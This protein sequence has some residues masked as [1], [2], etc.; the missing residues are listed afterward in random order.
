M[1]KIFDYLC[2]AVLSAIAAISPWFYGSVGLE[3]RYLINILCIL[4]LLIWFIKASLYKEEIIY[5][6]AYLSLF[7]FFALSAITILFS[8]Y[9]Y[10]SILENLNLLSYIIIFFIAT[11]ALN[12]EKRLNF[13]IWALCTIGFFYCGYGILQYYGYLPKV[14]W[15]QGNSLSSRFVNSGSFGAYINVFIFLSI[16]I[17]FSSIRILTR[18]IAVVFLIT[19]LIALALSNSRLSWITF[20]L[21]L[22]FL[23]YISFKY[24]YLVD[25][26]TLIFS[27]IIGIMLI[28]V[29]TKFRSLIWW[30]LS[31]AVETQYQSLH[32]RLDIWIG[33]LKLILAHPFGA[34]A[35]A[36]RYI[37]PTFRIHSDRF[38]VDYAHSDFLQI[39]SEL[40]FC[41]LGLFIWFLLSLL[42]RASGSLRKL[43]KNIFF[44]VSG[45]IC[46]ELSFIF[47]SF[48]DFPLQIPANAVLFFITLSLLISCV[49][50]KKQEKVLFNRLF[51]AIFIAISVVSLLLF[52]SIYLSRKYHFLAEKSF[53]KM[54]WQDALSNLDKS[55]KFM[56]LKA[57]NYAQKGRIYILK[58][59][60]S[61]GPNKEE[62]RKIALSNFL[63][64]SRLNPY[65]SE[66]Y[67]DLALVYA[68]NNREEGAI[69]SFKKAIT[70]NPADGYYYYSYADY[71]LE[72][73]LLDEAFLNYRKA[74]GLFTEEN[75]FMS[76]Y[77]TDP[78]GV[79]YKIYN[80]T[81]DYK[82]LKKAVPENLIARLKFAQFLETKQRTAEAIAEYEEILA[83][84]PENIE[85]KKA[86][87]KLRKG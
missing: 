86:V 74:M 7:C 36:F 34:G 16:G 60:L 14:F 87:E 43:P 19:F 31:I 49:S 64:A 5:Y 11:Q 56:P 75:R 15:A 37:Y 30:R 46:A 35:G 61:F 23:I 22:A 58:S 77:G 12:S 48:V 26:R 38:F 47:Q 18:V 40:G 25:R 51:S 66:Y 53:S 45:L 57:D 82:V 63:K 20:A 27:L 71:C 59:A 28:C 21:T 67:L 76:L 10:A 72:N 68:D 2:I 78:Y 29:I 44:I 41:G 9:R 69:Y 42:K 24:N 13:F 52:S 70:A 39:A 6:P 65:Q 17:I 79:F 32:Q 85:A 62:F 55:I 54:K 3:H 4:A 80:H 50:I 81:K 83:K 8:V 84:Y 33:T 1:K 73:N